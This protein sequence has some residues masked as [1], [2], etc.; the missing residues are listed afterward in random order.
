MMRVETM[1]ET[2]QC[3][4]RFGWIPAEPL[5][6][7]MYLWRLRDA[8]AVFTGRAHAVVWPRVREQQ[9]NR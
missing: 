4:P 7:G 1:H 2:Q 6:A 8:W 5:V 9:E 3:D